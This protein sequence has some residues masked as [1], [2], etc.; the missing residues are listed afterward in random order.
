MPPYVKTQGKSRTTLFAFDPITFDP[1]S[2]STQAN[3]DEN[4]FL[5]RE[6]VKLSTPPGQVVQPE[7]SKRTD[8]Y[9]HYHSPTMQR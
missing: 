3:A 6:S 8:R 1:P 9:C 5:R 2:S 7:I 4:A